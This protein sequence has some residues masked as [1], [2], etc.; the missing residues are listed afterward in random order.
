MQKCSVAKTGSLAY[1]WKHAHLI[2][3][4]QNI[5]FQPTDYG[6]K[7][8]NRAF[9]PVWFTGSQIM[10]NVLSENMEPEDRDE[11]EDDADD[12]CFIDDDS[13]DDDNADDEDN[14]G[15]D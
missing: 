3:L 14:D 11:D 2:D 10:P 13:E 1:L 7:E 5:Q 9:V 6:C 8:V 4:L 12:D 15:D